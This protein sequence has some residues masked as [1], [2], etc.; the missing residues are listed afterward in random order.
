[1]WECGR[2]WDLRRKIPACAGMTAM[3][4][5]LPPRKRGNDG[6]DRG[7]GA[8]SCADVVCWTLDSLPVF[9]GTWLTR[10]CPRENGGMTIWLTKPFP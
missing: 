6:G 10:A 9:T 1:M 7:G 4:V 3:G 2:E 5:G 8:L